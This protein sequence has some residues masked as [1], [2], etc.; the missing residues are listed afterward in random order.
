MAAV[1]A[2]AFAAFTGFES[3]AIYRREA[4]DPHRT[5]P[6]ATFIAVAFLGLFYA[7]IVWT[8]IQAYGSDKVVQAATDDAGGL[9]FAAITTYVGA[10]AADLMHVLIVSSVVASLLAFHNAINRYTLSLT[11][12]GLLPPVLGRIHPRHRSPY[13][14]GAAQTAVGAV[15]V[16]GFALAGADPYTQLLLW[17]NT[18]GMIGL[19]ALQLLVAAAVLC[20]FRRV[21]HGRGLAD[22]GRAG[23]RRAAARRRRR[24][25][26]R[27][28]RALFRRRDRHHHPPRLP[29][30]GRLRRRRRPR[31]APA[32]HP[33]RGL[34]RVRRRTGRGDTGSP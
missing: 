15:V 33:A 4:R 29:R 6:R 16:A 32:P 12:E 5:I 8:V 26:H 10:W 13:L 23:R 27:P 20:Y 19:M 25:G 21:R 22:G 34:R 3:T 28:C 31:A 11:E 9:F 24:P 2:C 17:V 7:F 18:P 1:L 30:P 14:A